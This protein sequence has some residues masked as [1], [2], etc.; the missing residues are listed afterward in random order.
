MECELGEVEIAKALRL[1]DEVI[2]HHTFE[3]G[4][5][6][7]REKSTRDE[8]LVALNIPEIVPMKLYGNEEELVERNGIDNVVKE[9]TFRNYDVAYEDKV[10]DEGI[11]VDSDIELC[12]DAIMERTAGICPE[13]DFGDDDD[14]VKVAAQVIGSAFSSLEET[15]CKGRKESDETTSIEMVQNTSPCITTI[16]LSKEEENG[17]I[18]GPGSPEPDLLVSDYGDE[19]ANMYLNGPGAS[20]DTLLSEASDDAAG[21]KVKEK[22]NF[23]VVGSIFERTESK[24]LLIDTDNDTIQQHDELRSIDFADHKDET[25]QESEQSY[26]LASN[27]LMPAYSEVEGKKD[28]LTT[29]AG[30]FDSGD[31]NIDAV[32]VETDAS[33]R[34]QSNRDDDICEKSKTVEDKM[35]RVKDVENA[36]VSSDLEVGTSN[37]IIP[38]SISLPNCEFF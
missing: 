2:S 8:E 19:Y 18:S 27:D 31:K 6:D 9:A 16:D 28:N 21:D 38:A 7:R 14:F 23:T 30:E 3:D 29:L 10:K 12:D 13:A 11:K 25:V 5:G 4:T 37:V 34:Y 36:D 15:I 35:Y 32:A 1:S 17:G 24:D 33:V 20:C 26:S 22:S